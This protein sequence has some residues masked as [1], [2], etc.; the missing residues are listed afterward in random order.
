MSFYLYLLCGLLGGLLGGMDMGGGT[1]LIPL[2]TIFLGVEQGVAQGVNLLSFLPMSAVAL[3]VHAKAGLL[4]GE[5]L[6][7]LCLPAL[8]FSVL[9]SLLA[10]RL[11]GPVLRCGFGAFLVVLAF[12]RLFHVFR[13]RK[14]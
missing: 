8:L 13:P 14:V 11:P 12:A 4:K 5:T 3:T 1:A 2:L 7:L 6:P 10:T 9:F